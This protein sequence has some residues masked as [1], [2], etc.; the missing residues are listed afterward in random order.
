MFEARNLGNLALRYYTAFDLPGIPSINPKTK[1]EAP[2]GTAVYNILQSS[3]RRKFLREGSSTIVASIQ[4]NAGQLYKQTTREAWAGRKSLPTYRSTFVPFR[5][6][7]THIAETEISKTKQFFIQ[8]GGF[9]HFL[10][11]ELVEKNLA[12]AKSK[13]PDF[14]KETIGEE[15]RSLRF[16]SDFSWKDEGAVE[17]V[18]RIM[19]GEYKLSDSQIRPDKM[20]KPG[21]FHLFLSY[22]FEVKPVALDPA[23]VCGVDLG[24]VIPAVCAVHDGHQRAYLGSGADVTA[25]RARFR[26]ERRRSQKRLGLYSNT[27]NWEMSEKELRW[28]ETYYHAL[29]RGVIDFCLKQGCGTIHVEDLASL[30]AEDVKSE[31]KRLMWIPSKFLGQLEYKAKEQGIAVV[32]INP[33]N[34]SRRCSSCG[35]IAEGNRPD[36]AKFV[37][38]KCGD[39]K[40]PVNADY[41]AAR[42]IALATGDEITHGYA[43]SDAK[44]F[45]GG[46]P[47]AKADE[48]GPA[49]GSTAGRQ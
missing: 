43:R 18:A 8:P 2:H 45:L 7:G 21:L 3:D 6:Q 36:Q 29:T 4:K 42:N 27:K 31:F 41:N 48:G 35:H 47:E 13:H 38:Q 12:Y 32:K 28:I 10:S 17:V 49:A 30:R 15:Q 26:A 16:V 23:R 14:Q 9:V 22:K 24:V 19:K 39:P 1:E 34:T 33:R 44:D 25:A 11:D 37:C 20:K 5:H 40:K 46:L